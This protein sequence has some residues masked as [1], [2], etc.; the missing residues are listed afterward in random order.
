MRQV[1]FS[2]YSNDRSVAFQIRTDIIRNE[3][4]MLTVEKS[5]MTSEARTHIAHN[6]MCAQ[7]LAESYEGTRF[8]AC[9]CKRINEDT[10][11]FEFLSGKQMDEMLDEALDKCDEASFYELLTIYK[12][13]MEKLA[14]VTIEGSDER[15]LPVANVDQIFQNI[16]IK[17]DKWYVYDYEW[18]FEKVV[19]LGYIFYRAVVFYGQF[20]RKADLKR[21]GIDL[22]DFFSISEEEKIRYQKMEKQ[23]QGYIQDGYTRLWEIY[24]II[25]PDNF[26]TIVLVE[27]EKKRRHPEQVTVRRNYFRQPADEERIE[28]CAKE[29]RNVLDIGV[30]AEIETLNISLGN[31]TG[32]VQM[33]DVSLRDIAGNILMENKPFLSNGLMVKANLYQFIDDIPNLYFNELPDKAVLHIEYN[34]GFGKKSLLTL[35]EKQL[36]AMEESTQ[37]RIQ[38]LEM[39]LERVREQN[40]LLKAEAERSINDYN[41]VVQSFAWRSTKPIRK[42]ADIVKG[43]VK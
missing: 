8:V 40:A 15:A 38:E 29:D 28:P 10:L 2:K 25:H 1:L 4:G 6:E 35:T 27:E 7:M 12:K 23:L 19:P 32:M 41:T 43:K 33:L 14:V 24:E 37:E 13:E 42:M 5:A 30:S 26:D 3:N 34:I 18:T 39:K 36:D 16:K 9:P 17:D 22:F 11:A 31:E 20:D 21:R